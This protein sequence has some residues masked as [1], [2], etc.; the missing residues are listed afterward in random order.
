MLAGETLYPQ[1]NNLIRIL[2]SLPVTSCNC[3]R[4][5]SVLRRLK[6]YL[7]TSTGEDRLTFLTLIHIYYD[8]EVD[9]VKL[10]DAFIGDSPYRKQRFR[11]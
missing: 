11:L 10:L 6:P 4:T 8:F 2:A 7:R 3:E 1:I 9:F 5:F